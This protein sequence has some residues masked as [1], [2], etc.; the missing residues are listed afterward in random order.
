MGG[1]DTD[2]VKGLNRISEDFAKNFAKSW[3]HK[4]LAEST[5]IFNKTKDTDLRN[6]LFCRFLSA[7]HV[8][9]IDIE[10]IGFFQTDFIYERRITSDFVQRDTRE[11]KVGIRG[12][13]IVILKKEIVRHGCQ[14]TIPHLTWI[15]KRKI[16]LLGIKEVQIKGDTLLVTLR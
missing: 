13:N 8:R 4:E 5:S 10:K 12:S 16:P 9:Y 1:M 2:I 11:M 14:H 6:K 15:E 7:R 3:T